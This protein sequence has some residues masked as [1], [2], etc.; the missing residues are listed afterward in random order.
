[1][2]GMKIARKIRTGNFG[3]NG[4]VLNIIAPFGGTKKSGFG[5]E[6]GE[7]GVREFFNSK[8]VSYS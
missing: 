8:S 5:R 6:M 3:I 4:G 2:K 1:M 7:Y